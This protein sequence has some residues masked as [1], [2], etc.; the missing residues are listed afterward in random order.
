MSA[1]GRKPLHCRGCGRHVGFAYFTKLDVR[2]KDLTCHQLPEANAQ[3]SRDDV[4][5]L[6]FWMGHPAKELSET[7]GLTRQRIEQIGY[8]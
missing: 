5:R 1:G 7:F 6:M 2:C 8:G 4:I 3:D